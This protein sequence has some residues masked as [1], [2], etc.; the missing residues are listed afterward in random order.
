MRSSNVSTQRNQECQ[1][2]GKMS[3][4]ADKAGAAGPLGVGRSGV[5]LVMEMSSRGWW[6]RV[7]G[8]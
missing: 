4:Y 2:P 3:G 5:G 8:D 7:H 1:H 6:S